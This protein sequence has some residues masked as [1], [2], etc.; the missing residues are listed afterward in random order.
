MITEFTCVDDNLPVLKSSTT[1]NITLNKGKLRST[2]TSSIKKQKNNSKT[3]WSI[4]VLYYP[5]T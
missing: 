5:V 4:D 3:L 1:Y 2:E